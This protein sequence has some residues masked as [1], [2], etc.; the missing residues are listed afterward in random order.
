MLRRVEYSNYDNG[1][2]YGSARV[3]QPPAR[4]VFSYYAPSRRHTSA[5][6]LS[7]GVVTV[8][9]CENKEVDRI[10]ADFRRDSATIQSI[11]RLV[12]TSIGPRLQR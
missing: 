2:G 11:G 1:D 10:W 4:C 6:S 12:Y 8:E 5:A 7:A 3:L 9:R